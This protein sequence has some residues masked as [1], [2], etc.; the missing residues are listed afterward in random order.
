[1][2]RTDHPANSLACSSHICDI[3]RERERKEGGDVEVWVRGLGIGQM[4][5]DYYTEHTCIL[6]PNFPG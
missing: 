4:E 3:Y 1:M 6:T 5:R 2:E